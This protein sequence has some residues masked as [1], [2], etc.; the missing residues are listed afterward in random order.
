MWGNKLDS[1][2]TSC[3]HYDPSAF[4]MT[5][6]YKIKIMLCCIFYNFSKLNILVDEVRY[7][8]IKGGNASEEGTTLLPIGR[9]IDF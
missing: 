8:K 7:T 2:L 1:A 4:S 6:E 3:S 5:Q 9:L